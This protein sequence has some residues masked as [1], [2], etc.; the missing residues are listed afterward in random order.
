MKVEYNYLPLEFANPRKIINQWKTLI[1]S[2]D[3]TLG[4]YVE[5]VQKAF[6]SY[7]GAKYCLAVNSGTDALILSLR[8]LSISNGDEVITS[9]NTFYATAGAI[10]ACGAKPILVDVDNSFQINVNEIEKKINKRTKAII[11]VHWA[12]ASP[13]IFAI[14]K[15]A[16]KYNIFVVEDACMGIGGSVDG[17]HPGTIGHV[18]AFSLHPLKSLNA[19]GDGGFFVTNNKKLYEWAKTYRNHGMINRDE[20]VMWGVNMRMQPLQA[21]VA[22]EGLKKIDSVIKKRNSNAAYLDSKL[23][24]LDGLITLPKRYNKNIETFSLYMILAKDRDKLY[25]YLKKNYIECKIHYPIPLSSQRPYTHINKKRDCK[26]ANF[27]AKNLITLPIHQYLSKKHLDYMY[28]KIK[29]FY[30]K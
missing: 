9:A 5:K 14:K 6:A 3:F 28:D 16:K 1:K 13:D 8:S 17:N 4:E 26:V 20:I 7:T 19:M 30:D 18:G 24:S 23:A 29:K 21:I 22:L 25:N 27:Q 11:A 10:V 12:G 2:C 15:I